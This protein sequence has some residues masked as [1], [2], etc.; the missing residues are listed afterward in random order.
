MNTTVTTHTSYGKRVGNS[1]KNILLWFVLLIA[2]IWL[3]AWNENNYLQEKNALKEWAAAV[4]ETSSSEI[5]PELDQKEVHL[6]WQLASP[7]EALVDSAFGV[8]VDD[9]KLKRT[10]E[11]YQ[12]VEDEDTTCTDNLGG[13]EDCTTTYSYRKSWEEYWINSDSF[14]EPDTH[15]N[16]ATWEYQSQEWEKQNITL[17]AY[18]LT[19]TFINKLDNYTIVDLTG[20]DIIIPEKYKTV[21]NNTNTVEDNNNSYL[22]GD[23]DTA[24]S[25]N[26]QVTNNNIYIWKDPAEPQIWDL[27]ITFSSVIPSEAS[28]VWRQAWNELTSYPTSNWRSIALLQLWNV[29]AE[30]MFLDA[31][32]ANQMMTW[33]IRFG[34]LLLMFIA[35]SMMMEFIETIAK[36]LPFL[37]KIVWVW[38][39]LIA[40][41][42]TLVVGFVT[43]GI[44][45]LAVRPVIWISCLVVAVA[46]IFL[47]IKWKKSKKE[48]AENSIPENTSEVNKAN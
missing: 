34:W 8:T 4:Q 48:A 2:S 15:R 18:K 5:N 9:L 17:W 28:I 39:R 42:L 45:W 12:W 32:K 1:F 20:Q 19:S 10:V 41:A 44:A 16:P 46:W 47:L 24:T 3:L 6:V 21:E 43:I 40:F 38:T 31:Q 35:F 14:K 37:S 22:Y 27:R 33:L 7:D 36:V 11:M 29:T 23:T 30:Q 13:S 26:F 25:N